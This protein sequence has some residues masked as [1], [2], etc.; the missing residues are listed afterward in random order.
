MKPQHRIKTVEE[1]PLTP[2]E[3]SIEDAIDENAIPDTSPELLVEV[4]AGL[5]ALA[6]SLR[7]GKRPGAGRKAREHVK[8]TVLLSPAVR[9]KLESL[10][11]NS[12]S[13]SAAVEKA[14]LAF[15]D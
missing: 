13:L 15:P 7:G 12:G 8:T 5:A 14:V 3:Q 10:A 11:K 6:V 2:Y 1:V 4:R 9:T